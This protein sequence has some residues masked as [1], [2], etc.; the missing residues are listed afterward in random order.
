MTGPG[1][2]AGS[3]LARTFAIWARNLPAFAAAA[4]VVFSPLLA[5]TAFYGEALS[6]AFRPTRELISLILSFVLTGAVTSLVLR[7]LAGQ[8]GGLAA[9]L[10]VAA[11]RVFAIFTT[12]FWGG[13][14]VVG[15][16]L[17][18][19]LPG[20]W[21]FA[22]FFVAVPV[23]V[24][25]RPGAFA[26]LWRSAELTK[27]YRAHCLAAALLLTLLSLGVVAALAAAAGLGETRAGL[28]AGEA[29]GALVGSLGSVASAVAYHDL[30]VA[31]EGADPGAMAR[32]FE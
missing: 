30:R 15:G 27:G 13:L 25:E 10:G 32:V 28:I 17:L 31:K 9:S 3:L 19:V 8:R 16:L 20:L 18:L 2:T 21:L 14:A 6:A 12:S 4:L 22:V 23:A 26:S 29:I 11:E 5:L 7:Q 24:V 1:L